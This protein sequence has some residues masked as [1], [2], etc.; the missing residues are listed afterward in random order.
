ME[1]GRNR[2]E[3]GSPDC[4]RGRQQWQNIKTAPAPSKRSGAVITTSFD[5]N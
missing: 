2:F 5:K 3:L 4:W 1:T